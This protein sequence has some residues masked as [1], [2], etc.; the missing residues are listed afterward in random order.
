MMSRMK[1]VKKLFRWKGMFLVFMVCLTGIVQAQGILKVSG[2]KIVNANNQEII[3]RGIGLGNWLVN[4]GYMMGTSD[5]ANSPTE[6][7]NKI[8]SLVG[9][10]SADTFFQAYRKNYLTRK[11]I[12]KLAEWGFNSIRVPL[13]YQLFT[14]KKSPYVYIN[15]GVT[16]IDSLLS[17]CGANQIY[18]ILDLHC[19]PGG[20]NSLN[21]S[22]YQGAP[23]LWEST[24][25]QQ[26]TIDLWQMLA[27]HYADQQWIG[28]YDLINEPA[29][30]L[31]P[32][33]KPLHDLYVS[34]TTAIRKVDSNHIIFI[35]GNW[36]AT[37]FTG[38]TP[39]WDNNMVYSFHKYWNSNDAASMSSLLNLRSTTNK[40]LWLGESGENSNEWFASCV[41]LMEKNS[42]G[43]SWWPHKKFE[44]ISGLL[45]VPQTTLYN[46][47]LSYWRGQTSQPSQSAA[48]NALLGMAGKVLFDSCKYNSDVVDALMRQSRS[49]ATSPFTGNMI[50]GNIYAVNYDLGRWNYAYK[51]N[52]YQ[53]INGNGGATWNN[54]WMYRNDGVDI[55]KCSDTSTNGYCV[56]SINPGEFLTFTVQVKHSS[57]YQIRVRAAANT[58]GGLFTF[59]WDNSSIGTADVPMTG[60]AQIWRTI[61]CGMDSLVA[62]AHTLKIVFPSGGFNLNYVQFIDLHQETIHPAA[63][64]DIILSQN[65]P[66]PF[67]LA[68]ATTILY[69]LP[70]DGDVKIEVFDVLGR[71]IL[72]SEEG[73]KSN[74][75]NSITLD[76]TQFARTSGV[77][78][79]RVLLDGVKSGVGKCVLVK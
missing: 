42:I 69:S 32:S 14:P 45:S 4:E 65:Y 60:G 47:L 18:L 11:D 5:F 1:R 50:P 31:P 78:F 3:L 79:Y 73:Q 2:T 55:Q 58:S 22:D 30:D 54:G 17:W 26:R 63:G 8:S 44:S 75:T 24:L 71:K 36:F 68:S 56:A 61:D 25:N 27:Q 43:W 66:N 12:Q 19:A 77:Y 49:N 72:F 28:G 64:N 20:Q 37:D 38:L 35:E 13:H 10:A 34:I 46:N 52:D 62:G 48:M 40:P 70:H 33:N 41:N 21:I 76:G 59:S 51:D 53:N 23:S 7:Y 67:S 9:T 15:D 57:M 39:P 74:G 16:I 29:W 6:I